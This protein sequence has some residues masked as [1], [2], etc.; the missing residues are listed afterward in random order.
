MKTYKLNGLE[1][2]ICAFSKSDVVAVCWLNHVGV[3]ELNVV[4]TDIPVNRDAI[5]KLFKS[6]GE[7][8]N[9]EVE[10]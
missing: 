8:Q 9:F 1:Y 7:Y 10:Y 4:E 5:G 6:L 2:Y 3:T